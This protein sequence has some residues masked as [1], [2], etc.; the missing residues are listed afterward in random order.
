M[1]VASWFFLSFQT[2][3]SSS[4]TE[5]STPLDCILQ[6]WDSFDAQ[7]LKK[8]CL[9]F[10]YTQLWP[11]HKLVDGEAWPSEGSI[12]YNTILQLDLFCR[13]EEKWFEVPCGQA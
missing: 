1:L 7:T 9:I 4:T 3:N 2:G 6:N 11:Q 12:N 5:V 13:R 10:I 8:K